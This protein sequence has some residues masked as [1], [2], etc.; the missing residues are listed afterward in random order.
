[1]ARTESGGV[2][3]TAVDLYGSTY[4]AVAVA[5]LLLAVND[6]RRGASRHQTEAREWLESHGVE[7]AQ[8]LGLDA[9]G[10]RR[11]LQELT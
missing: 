1:M 10:F 5:I 3:G 11:H 8:R 2:V 9:A 4:E 6:S 7:L